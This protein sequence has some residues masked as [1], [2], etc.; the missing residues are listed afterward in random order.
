MNRKQ[1]RLRNLRCSALKVTPLLVP[2]LLLGCTHRTKSPTGANSGQ[3]KDA[4]AALD[5]AAHGPNTIPDAVL[6]ATKCIVVIPSLHEDTATVNGAGVASCRDASNQWGAPWPVTFEGNRSQAQTVDLFVLVLNDT[7]MRNLRSGRLQ[8][9]PS[10]SSLAPLVSTTPVP[11][12]VDVSRESMSYEAV[13][14]VLSSGQAKGAIAGAAPA[15]AAAPNLLE[16][17]RGRASYESALMSLF[18]RIVP[19]GIVIHHTAVL[20]MA[21]A[22]P[23]NTGEVDRYHESRGFEIVCEGR[24]YHV[25]YHYLILPDGRVQAGRPERCEGAH[26]RGYNSYLGI[27]VVGD[28]SSRDNP[29]GSK[30][31]IRPSEA[32][33]ASL[34]RLCRELRTRYRIP[35]Q[36]IV[37]HSDISSTQCPGDRFP[38]APLLGKLQDQSIAVQ[39]SNR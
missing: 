6:N 7:G 5:R 18:N 1:T 25:A 36:H 20:P 13:G 15:T 33:I 30:G 31:L 27:S 8:I 35:L 29:S 34:V 12:Q 14:G 26:A 11:T 24:V 37:R 4:T 32:Q 28:F 17:G 16:T 23:A 21:T 3:V 19:T 10:P 9:S 2:L 22:P 38:F 39:K